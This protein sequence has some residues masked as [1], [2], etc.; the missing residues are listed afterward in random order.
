MTVWTNL[1]RL[2]VFAVIA[3]LLISAFSVMAVAMPS[4]VNGDG[5]VTTTDARL[6][7]LSLTG[8]GGLTEDQRL[9]ADL[10]GD[11]EITTADVRLL[12][13]DILQTPVTTRPTTMTTAANTT[14]TLPPT[15]TTTWILTGPDG[16][17]P[18]TYITTTTG[19]DCVSTNTTMPT[20]MPYGSFTVTADTISAHG[21]DTIT[22]PIRISREHALVGFEMDIYISPFL[23]LLAVNDDP[24]NPYA[25]AL[26]TAIF[27]DEAQWRVTKV[28]NDRLNIRY[29]SSADEGSLDGGVLFNLTFSVNQISRD[30]AIDC[31]MTSYLSRANGIDYIPSVQ[32]VS[33]VVHVSPGT[34]LVPTTTTTAHG[35][36]TTTTTLP[37]DAPLCY[38]GETLTAK[39][40]ETFDWSVDISACHSLVAL[41]MDI[42]YDPDVLTWIPEETT[43][44]EIIF[45]DHAA[46][47]V[48][49]VYDGCIRVLFVSAADTG[50]AAGGEL[51]SLQFQL[52]P[53]VEVD[54]DDT[55]IYITPTSTLSAV[56]GFTYYQKEGTI[57]DG[58]IQVASR[59]TR[60]K[61][62][63]TTSDDIPT[64]YPP[65]T[66]TFVYD[67]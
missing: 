27:T 19:Y 32:T 55:W 62:T 44:N 64:T 38:T 2:T 61:F 26:N 4:D 29:V 11:G 24:R 54:I 5:D 47:R 15:T 60:P 16:T 33:G 40:G 21:G 50:D 12:L 42:H 51:L 20:T 18:T 59:T 28:R 67:Q 58:H 35:W 39:V 43:L 41:E 8:N 53:D 22:V 65:T 36:P 63:T 3:A 37:Y 17:A 66:T 1:R 9:A 13:S 45:D 25:T 34:T 57:V 48:T 7:L 14:T 6:M 52:R 10:N 56:N 49:N 30:A 31:Y 46:W 23:Q